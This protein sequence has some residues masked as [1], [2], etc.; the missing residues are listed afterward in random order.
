MVY[1]VR[2]LGLCG[3]LSLGT[4]YSLSQPSSKL[5]CT[6][7]PG[8]FFSGPDRQYAVIKVTPSSGVLNV[9]K[10]RSISITF[11]GVIFIAP[12]IM[13]LAAFY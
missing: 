4:Y 13:L 10:H 9:G 7:F 8:R 11:V 5:C 2:T 6:P 1:L 3:F 12:V